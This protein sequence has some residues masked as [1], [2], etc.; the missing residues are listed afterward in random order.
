MG[1]VSSSFGVVVDLSTLLSPPT[2]SSPPSKRSAVPTPRE[3]KRSVCL[4]FFWWVGGIGGGSVVVVVGNNTY[5]GGRDNNNNDNNAGG[6]AVGCAGEVS[7]SFGVVVDLSTLLYI[8]RGLAPGPLLCS[9][10]VS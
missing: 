5:I 2:L 1:E 6:Q 7:S 9:Q 3:G 10:V 8:S 4:I